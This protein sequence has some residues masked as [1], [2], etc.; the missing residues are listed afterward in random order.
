MQ[1]LFFYFLISFFPFSNCFAQD[2]ITEKTATGKAKKF[3]ERGIQSSFNSHLK[4]ALEDF[5]KVLSIEPRFVDARIHWANVHYDLG[6]LDLAEEGFEKA[7]AIAPD[8]NENVYYNVGLIEW[9]LNKFKEAELHF[10][11]YLEMNPKS[12]RRLS[13]AKVHLRNSRFAA[14]AMKNPVAFQPENLGPNINTRESEYLPSFTADGETLIFTAHDGWQEDFYFS[15]KK[16]GQWERRQPLVALNTGGNEGGQ[17]ISADGKIIVFTACG[18]RDGLGNCDLYISEFKGK[19][20]MPA[21]NMGRPVNSSAKEKQ[22]SLT[23]DGKTLFFASDRRGTTGGMDLWMS[24]RLADGSWSAPI[25]LASLNTKVHD[26]TP[27]IH[28]DGQTLY[29][30][31]NGRQGMGESDIYLSRKQEDGT[32]GAP[33]NLGYPINT[34]KED[35][36][37]VVS[38]DGKTGYFASNRNDF[39]NAQGKLDI[40]Q[41]EMPESIRP[42]P[43]TYVKAKVYDAVTKEELIAKVEF[44][45]LATTKEHAAAFTDAL[46]GE[47]LVTLPI[48]KDYALNVS[49][50][51]Y[52][53]HSEHFSLASQHDIGDP[54]ILEIP[55]QP[56]P[57]ATSVV[58]ENKPIILKNIFFET[59]SAELLPASITELNWLKQL[60]E[61]NPQIKIII[62]GHTDNVGT[63]EDNNS[64]SQN[65]AKA[66]YEFL[67]N[68]GIQV[69]RLQYQGFGETKPIDDNETEEGRQNNRRTEFEISKNS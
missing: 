7:I 18:R 11:Q 32:W 26:R 14:E 65:R 43:I 39:E 67:I 15:K 42:Q 30:M 50:K 63:E 23:S 6:N 54:Y 17:T 10:E 13:R 62:S 27:F 1:R 69:E 19:D 2:Y 3:Y 37:L 22:P 59:A 29:F 12:T 53:F 55:L 52:L 61:D 64:L 16:N 58:T 31:S 41:F 40:Y 8:Y 24:K 66:V 47:F 46:N 4:A 56:I 57:A 38:P 44:V 5:E 68:N 48:G 28:Q 35:G 25:N 36:L 21:Q 51:G 33:E 45:N 49:K 34:K 20:W 60:L 9:K